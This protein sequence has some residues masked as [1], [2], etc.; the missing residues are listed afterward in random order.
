MESDQ[1]DPATARRIA[2]RAEAAPYV[3]YPPTPWWYYPV[4]GLWT[5]ALAY[6]L[7]LSLTSD[8]DAQPWL[9][10]LIALEVLFIQWLSR[11][12]G[13]MPSFRN[14]PPEFRAVLARYLV[15][16]VVVLAAAVAAGALAG[17]VAAA[18]TSLVLV[19]GALVLH[20]RSFARAAVRVRERLG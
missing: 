5:A 12:H 3:D 14:P 9:V 15:G 11:R 10:L 7:T 2:E 17:P 8:R 18:T 6:L 4:V 19:T 16:V 13:A 20:E 1:L